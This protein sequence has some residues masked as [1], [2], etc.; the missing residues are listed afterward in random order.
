MSPFSLP[1]NILN[2]ILDDLI[3]YCTPNLTWKTQVFV[4][5]FKDMKNRD[6][7]E[8][9]YPDYKDGFK[10]GRHHLHKLE[11]IRRFE[12]TLHDIFKVNKKVLQWWDQ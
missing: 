3:S 5:T 11:E 9:Q 4:D 8:V 10:R 7:F 6:T 12:I 2:E 1:K